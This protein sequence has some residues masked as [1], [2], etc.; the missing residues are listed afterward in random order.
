MKTSYQNFLIRDWEPSD[1]IEA[2]RVIGSVLAEY[3]LAW[4]PTEADRD[5]L[6]VETFYWQSGGEFWIVEDQGQVVGTAG[7]YPVARGHQGVEIR[8]MYLLPRVRGL[9]LG[10]FL[11]AQLESAIALRQFE[12]I[13]IET[14]SVLKEAVQ[15][16][17]SSG[18]QPS[19][20]VETQ[21]CDRVYVKLLSPATQGSQC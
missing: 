5:V 12:M 13:W 9:G 17:E 11:L 19:S 21:R 10:R 8:K 4:H 16:Y 7:Y 2:A 15:L 3:G 18:Y 14:A 1:R 20:G 6:E